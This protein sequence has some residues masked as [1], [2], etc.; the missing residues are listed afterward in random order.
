LDRRLQV[1]VQFAEQRVN[2]LWHKG[3]HETCGL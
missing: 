2:L 1:T 3:F